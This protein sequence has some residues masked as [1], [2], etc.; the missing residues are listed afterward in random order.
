GS[1]SL[2]QAQ[3]AP[4]GLPAAIEHQRLARQF[5]DAKSW[6]KALAEAKLATAAAPTVPANRDSW[7]ILA[8]TED[9][10]GHLSEAKNAYAKYLSLSPAVEK[11]PLVQ[12]RLTELETKLDRDHRYKWGTRSAGLILGYSPSFQATSTTEIK[13][14][15]STAMDLGLRFDRFQFGFKKA[16][17]KAGAFRAPTT[18]AANPP[19]AAVA[20][21]ARH[22]IE[23]VYIQ[24]NFDLTSE[25]E[26]KSIVWSIPLYMAGVANSIRTE[27][28]PEKHYVNFGMDIASGISANLYTK[29]AF[30]FD[31]TALYHLGIPFGEMASNE[32]K[33]PIKTT[34]GETISG[35][36]TAFE[37]RL[38]LKILFGATPPSE[39]P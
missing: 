20:A 24:T 15:M 25:P 23:E 35:S 9:R 19:Y 5:V 32:E 33:A 2:A 13:G 7:L 27:S 4:T 30:S 10:L 11:R 28:T 34:A 38:G 31:I 12:Q 37:V 1:L 22:V 18:T 14:D 17:G 3:V 6:V 21:G 36:T 39:D 29:S 26:R 16:V 8:A